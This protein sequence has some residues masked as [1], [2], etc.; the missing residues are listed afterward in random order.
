MRGM[1]AWIALWVAGCSAAGPEGG[2]VADRDVSTP[3]IAW[4]VGVVSESPNYIGGDIESGSDAF[5]LFEAGE[6][7]EIRLHV[8]NSTNPFDYIHLHLADGG[9]LGEELAPNDYEVLS[10]GLTGYWDLEKGREYLFEVHVPGGG[11]F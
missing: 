3:E 4:S 8:Q 11:F 1:W 5:F 10:N 9:Q 6:S 2:W 7:F